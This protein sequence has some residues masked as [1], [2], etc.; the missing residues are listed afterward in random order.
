MLPPQLLGTYRQYKLDTDS[1][2]SWLASTA[3]SRGYSADLLATSHSTPA[4]KTSGRLKGKARA[5]AR[6][7]GESK[8][9]PANEKKH[10]IAIK[11]FVPLANF[12]AGRRVSVP[13]IFSTTIDRLIALRSAF[14]TKLGE[15]GAKADLESDKKHEYFVG[16]LEAVREA[17]R[18]RMTPTTAAVALDAAIDANKDTSRDPAQG[19]GGRFAA[20]TVDEP[21]ES[22]LNMF[23]NASHERPKPAQDD[24]TS[25]E[26][27][28]PTTFDDIY[29][30]FA[31]LMMD[32][33]LIR[34]RIRWIWS[35]H[36]KGDFDLAAAAVATNTAVSVAAG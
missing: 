34:A 12:I 5:K 29:F 24:A 30:A 21:S 13:D 2:A 11:D 10:I 4:P 17:L 25:Y 7:S 16:I 3:I 14:G 35:R 33:E 31:A 8:P 32:L 36:G 18:P 9:K 23:S 20:L 1:V 28:P 22:F 19:L 26:A 6:S 15:T 27:E